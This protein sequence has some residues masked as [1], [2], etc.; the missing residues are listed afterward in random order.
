MTM[1]GE[2][3]AKAERELP[4]GYHLERTSV[5]LWQNAEDYIRGLHEIIQFSWIYIMHFLDYF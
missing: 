5:N 3:A 4:I 1:I 2:F